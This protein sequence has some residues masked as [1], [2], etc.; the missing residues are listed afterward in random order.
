MKRYIISIVVVILLIISPFLLE[1]R[2]IKAAFV[3]EPSMWQIVVVTYLGAIAS[4]VLALLTYRIVLQNRAQIRARLAF[5]VV[6]Y[7][8][9]YYLKISNLGQENAYNIKLCIDENFIAHVQSSKQ[10]YFRD[11]SNPFFIEAGK[12]IYVFIGW[13]NDINVAWK[14]KNIIFYVKGEYNNHYKVNER[15][16]MDQFI[17][18]THFIVKGDLENTISHIKNGLVVQNNSYNPIQ[19]SLD[20]ISKTLVDLVEKLSN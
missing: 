20:L 3:G 14:G 18:K 8:M 5:S 10:Q 15:L 6:I 16:A 1:I 9:G 2:Y 12:S 11:L 17:N 19:K 7:E 13:Y 4:L